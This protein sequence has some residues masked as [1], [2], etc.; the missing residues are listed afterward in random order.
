MT[1]PQNKTVAIFYFNF[2]MVVRLRPSAGSLNKG[3]IHA[4]F[5][6]FSLPKNNIIFN[7][8][9][10]LFCSTPDRKKKACRAKQFRRKH[11]AQ[12]FFY[13][14]SSKKKWNPLHKLKLF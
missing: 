3:F 2:V 7:S 4:H 14:C 1:G 6:P 9:Q 10:H 13:F 5:T 11:T 8:C 12:W